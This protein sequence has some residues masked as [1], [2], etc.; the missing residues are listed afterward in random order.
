[1]S[2]YSPAIVQAALEFLMA[3]LHRS[4][5]HYSHVG[6]AVQVAKHRPF[7]L[8]FLAKQTMGDRALEAEVLGLFGKQLASAQKTLVTADAFER[9]QLA[10]ALKGT[11]RGLGAFALAEVAAKMEFDPLN[12]AL[13]IQ[14]ERCIVEATDFIAS[15][16]R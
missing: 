8:A 5:D 15:L 16:N 10:H 2:F 11:G 13:L 14:M 1:L 4:A 9:K 7:D 12:R 3:I 6:E